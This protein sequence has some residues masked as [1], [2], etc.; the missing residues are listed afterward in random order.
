MSAVRTRS[1]GCGE[2]RVRFEMCVKEAKRET[3]RS[4]R[5]ELAKQLAAP[6][7]TE[8]SN[9]KCTRLQL[10]SPLALHPIRKHSEL[11]T[12]GG[13]RVSRGEML[14]SKGVLCLRR[15]LLPANHLRMPLRS[16]WSVR[17][18]FLSQGTRLVSSRKLPCL[19]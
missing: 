10:L 14:V 8:D 9:Q 17:R 7:T 13:G 4:N 12:A 5:E 6:P 2:K 19:S 1:V 3:M 11:N 15:D 18:R 16:T